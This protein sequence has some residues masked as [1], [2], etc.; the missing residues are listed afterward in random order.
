VHI[1]WC[2]CVKDDEELSDM[3]SLPSIVRVVKPRRMR[4]AGHVALIGEGGAQVCTV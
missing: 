3:Y 4:W 1:V 2:M